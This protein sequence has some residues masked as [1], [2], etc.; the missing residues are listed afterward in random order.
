MTLALWEKLA[1]V[2]HTSAD[3]NVKTNT[4][5]EFYIAKHVNLNSFYRYFNIAIDVSKRTRANTE[6]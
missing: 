3:I 6:K 4:S 1:V 2:G 5:A